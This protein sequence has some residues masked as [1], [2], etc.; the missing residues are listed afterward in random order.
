MRL[1]DKRVPLRD[2]REA[3]LRALRPGEGPLLAELMREVCADTPYMARTPEEW[4]LPPEQA[5]AFVGAVNDSPYGLLI[6]A[7]IG[8]T[9]AGTC[10]LSLMHR[11]KTAHRGEIAIGV[12]REFRELGLGGALMREAIEF[13]RACGL[14]QL[15]LSYIEG[16]ERARRLYAR[17]GFVPVA[18]HPNAFRQ[19]DGTLA[20]ECFMVLVLS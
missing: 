6:A 19:Q 12:R 20:A 1:R 18:V 5:E 9:V 15:E 11:R 10:Q 14:S 13:A 2:G 3:C 16:N 7:E 17:F 4:D 8:G